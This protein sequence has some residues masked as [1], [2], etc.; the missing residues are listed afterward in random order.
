MTTSDVNFNINRENQNTIDY[1]TP[2]AQAAY[3]PDIR[4]ITFKKKFYTSG[5][6][7][8]LLQ[9]PERTMRR[10]L[11][12]GKVLGEQ[13]PITGTWKI[14]KEALIRFVADRCGQKSQAA[15]TLRVLVI[16]QDTRTWPA[17]KLVLDRPGFNIESCRDACDALINIGATKPDLVIIDAQMP[18]LNGG[19]LI[20]AIRRNPNTSRLAVLLFGRNPQELEALKQLGAD[21]TVIEPVSFDELNTKL[22]ALIT[23]A[24][25]RKTTG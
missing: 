15:A 10:Y 13:H 2:K 19:D 24:V 25:T 12:L 20:K 4:G 14:S 1:H 17:L 8:R 22:D 21:D 3:W 6:A 7:A 11:S 18:T 16:H 9:I 23:K 5:Q